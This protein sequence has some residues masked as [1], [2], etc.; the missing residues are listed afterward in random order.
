MDALID[1]APAATARRRLG[2]LVRGARVDDLSARAEERVLELV[3]DEPEAPTADLAVQA[4]DAGAVEPPSG[5]A[6]RVLALLALAAVLGLL[7]GAA[8]RLRPTSHGRQ[9]LARGGAAPRAPAPRGRDAS[10]GIP[11]PASTAPQDGGA[12]DAA[13]P[14]PPARVAGLPG[15]HGRSTRHSARGRA[16]TTL[17][18]EARDASPGPSAGAV[19]PPD[20]GAPTARATMPGDAGST[21]DAAHS[22]DTRPQVLSSVRVRI[23]SQPAGMIWVDGRYVGG[24]PATIVLSV[25]AHVLGAGLG[26]ITTTRRVRVLPRGNQSFVLHVQ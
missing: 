4:E 19:S 15:R 14:A 2:E 8:R 9:Q 21:L 24:S 22:S 5:G 26:S 13:S 3:F 23:L 11:R 10:S 17:L 20:A 25:G 7:G 18:A 12:V 16:G 6:K 1:C